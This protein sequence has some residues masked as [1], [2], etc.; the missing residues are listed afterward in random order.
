MGKLEEISAEWKKLQQTFD[1]YTKLLG[2][3]YPEEDAFAD[4]WIYKNQL[5][6]P[7]PDEQTIRPDYWENKLFDLKEQV[8]LDIDSRIA[9]KA[10]FPD[11][12]QDVESHA[13]N[14]CK[15]NTDSLEKIMDTIQNWK[16]L[17]PKSDL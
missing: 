12:Y 14:F 8:E 11:S 13:L 2:E 16:T 5:E 1:S 17:K 6:V 9:F 3:L 7:F 10:E 4:E 15:I